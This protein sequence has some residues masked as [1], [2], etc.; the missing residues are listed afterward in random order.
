[1]AQNSKKNNYKIWLCV[2]TEI[3]NDPESISKV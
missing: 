2:K 3:R 1:M